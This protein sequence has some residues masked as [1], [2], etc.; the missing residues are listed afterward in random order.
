MRKFLLIFLFTVPLAVFSAEQKVIEIP[1]KGMSC[2]F[3]A[4]G[5]EKN[6]S[7]MPGVEKCEVSSTDGIARITL[8]PGANVDLEALKSAVVDSGFSP[9]EATV[10]SLSK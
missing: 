9:G 8:A 3:C 2:P 1:V 7:K 6:I 5:V 4:Y 10:K